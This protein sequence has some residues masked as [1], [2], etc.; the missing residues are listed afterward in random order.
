MQLEIPPHGGTLVNRFAGPVER[1]ALLE[2]AKSFRRIHLINRRMSDLEMIA[3]GA[4]SP[5][6]GFMGRR[7]YESVVVNKRLANGLPWT[8]PITLAIPREEADELGMNERLALVDKYENVTAILQMEE[9]YA[10][11]REREARL[12]YGTTDRTHSG[13]R[14]LYRRGEVQLG[15]KIILLNRPVTSAGFEEYRHDPADTRAIFAERGWR[16]IVGF[17]TRNP[18]H[19]A[20]EY[21]QK[22]ALETMDGML[23]HPLVGETKE[24]DIPADVRMRC[25]EVLLQHFYPPNK[26]LL[27]VNPAVMRYAG[28]RE[29]IFHAIL[30]K[31][32]GCTHFIVGRDHAGVRD[33]YGPFDAQ[34]IFDEFTPDELGITPLFFDNTFF[35]KTCGNMASTKTCPHPIEDHVALS[36]TKVR[37]LLA[38]GKM[39]PPEV[40]RPE[41]AEILI[42]AFRTRKHG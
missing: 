29:A 23:L 8:I 12:V 4:F 20:H 37:S 24:D 26:V 41:V 25:Y 7:D 28:P 21:I 31:N 18:I 32:Y 33:Y 6:E 9:K 11:D 34:Y 42:E 13:V 30:R 17:Q 1:E 38:E 3:I 15:G 36:G 40:T 27:S 19:R 2:E 39:P 35:C 5:L 10:W 14:N 22:C 16:R